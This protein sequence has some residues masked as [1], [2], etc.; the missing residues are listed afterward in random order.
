MSKEIDTDAAVQ[1]YTPPASF[2]VVDRGSAET[3][4]FNTIGDSFV[5]IFEYLTELVDAEGEKF[6]QALFTGADGKAY[7]IFP[8]APLRRGLTRLKEG[9][10]VRITYTQDIDTGR[11][12][13]MKS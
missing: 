8:G 4:N 10:W 12:S 1:V 6:P 2:E 5:G 9:D 7:C 13:P 11:P 3:V